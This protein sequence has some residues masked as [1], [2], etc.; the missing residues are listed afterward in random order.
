ML[1]LAFLMTTTVYAS[2]IEVSGTIS[3]DTTWAGVDTVKVVGDIYVNNGIT[4]TI[5]P[6]IYV[7]FQGHY[8]LEV[9][10]TLLAIGTTSTMITFTAANHS[11]GWNRIVLDNTPSSNDS[12]KI[13]YCKLE[14]GKANSGGTGNF[15]GAIY[16]YSYDKVLISHST[17]SNNDADWWGG[18]VYCDNSNIE[19]QYCTFQNNSAVCGGG[20][21]IDDCGPIL[22]NNLITNNSAAN[23]GGIFFVNSNTT[24]INN[25]IVNNS[26][27]G[28]WFQ[29]NSDPTF[30]NTIIY[31]STVNE[32]Y[33]ESNSD[34]PNFYY[35]DIEGGTSWFGGPGAGGNFTGDYENCID[36]NPQ[37][38]G[39]GDHPY[40]ISEDSPCINTGDPN[41]TTTDVG[42]YDL[43]AESRIQ[44][45]II[46]IGAYE[47]YKYPDGFPGNALEFDGS[48]DYVSIPSDPSFDN[49]Q[50]TVEFWVKTDNPGNWDG[51]IDKG[52]STNTDWYFLTGNPGQT[53]GVIFGIG[54]GTSRRELSYS[55]NDNS[56]HHVAG[57]FDGTTMKLIIDGEIKD[58]DS[59]SMSNTSNNICL[60]SRRDLGWNFAGILEEVVIWDVCRSL[61]EIRENKHLTL[62]GTEPGLVSYYQ[63]NESTGTYCIELISNNNGTL[64]NM[65]TDSCWVESTIPIGDGQSVTQIVNS[66]GMVYFNDAGLVMNVNQKTGTDTIVVTRI[67]RVPNIN[68]T[69]PEDVFDSQYWVINKFGNGTIN[70]NLGFTVQED[71]TSEDEQHPEQIELYTRSSNVDTDWLFL[72]SATIVVP[73]TD[74][75]GFFNITDFSQFIICRN[76]LPDIHIEVDTLNFGTVLI[77]YSETDTITIFN[78]GNDTLFVT[79]ISNNNLDFTV[80]TTSCTISPD[81]SLNIQVTYSPSYIGVITDTLTITSN[82]PDEPNVEVILIGEGVFE[83]D[84]FPGNALEFDGTDDYVRVAHNSGLPI[85]YYSSDHKFTIS[86]WVKGNGQDGKRVFSEGYDNYSNSL[87]TIGTTDEGK[88]KVFIQMQNGTVLLNQISSNIA[89]DNTWHHIVWVDINNDQRLYID[90]V[91]DPSD[92]HYSRAGIQLNRTSIGAILGS[93]PSDFFEGI[94]DEVQIW[95]DDLSATQ[96]RENMHLTLTGFETW[97]VSYLQFNEGSGE[98]TYDLISENNGT[99]ID[100]EPE[101][102]VNSTIPA[103]GGVSNTQTE[104]VGTVNFT[105]TGLSMYFNSQNGASITVTRIDMCPNINPVDA[106]TVFDSQYW[107]VNRFGSGSFNA[108]LTFTI[109]EDLTAADENNPSNIKLYTRPSNADTN[110]VY[111]VDAS[112]VNATT[113]EA[114]FDGITEFSQFIIGKYIIPDITVIPDSLFETLNTDGIATQH[115]FIGNVGNLNLDFTIIIS[116]STSRFFLKETNENEKTYNYRTEWLSL[117]TYSGTVYPDSTE[118]ITVYFDAAGLFE[119]EYTKYIIITSNDPDEPEVIVPVTLHVIEPNIYVEEDSLNFGIVLTDTSKVDT[120]TIFNIGTDT[121][122]VSDISNNNLDFIV[123]PAYCSISPDDSLDIQVTFSP[124]TIGVITDTLYITS[125]DPDEPTVTVILTGEG[126]EPPPDIVVTPA[127]FTESLNPGE[128]SFQE[129]FIE[130]TGN[131]NL[132]FTIIISDSTSRFFFKK[133]NENEK[134]YNYRT[135]WLSLE[136]YS[137]TVYPD[138]TEDITVYFDATELNGGDYSKYLIITSNDPDEPEIVVPVN[139]SVGFVPDIPQNVTISVW[140]DSI[141]IIWDPVTGADSYKVYSSDNAFTGFTEDMSGAFDGTSWSAPITEEKKFYYVTAS[142]ESGYTKTTDSPGI[143]I[144]KPEKPGN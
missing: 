119:G 124:S 29:D 76:L 9:D 98:I 102:W 117:E 19:I 4:L 13:V 133:T 101:D 118:D 86:M 144:S 68:P 132:D 45:G 115:L 113:D 5:A 18:G 131:G 49:P 127:F 82:D 138:S 1:G 24:L 139:L 93:D 6:G 50:F 126:A 85:Y 53:D 100:M 136:T 80:D 91:Q 121:L 70:A 73:S 87:F 79:D 137:G 3:S 25:T 75:A 59:Y 26:D 125:N 48:D 11:T 57:T 84:T 35:C 36:A 37:F 123:N 120:F 95:E 58:S 10:G 32:V 90:G 43:S 77:V 46:D 40:D 129:L 39:S 20:I 67:N 33:L 83:T 64:T 135:E 12:S 63:F 14:Y 69:E 28:I 142:G 78:Y 71:L 72:S 54:N 51:I 81:D 62:E 108:D 109:S 140:N 103:G 44:Q 130:N 116:D 114:T 122:F 56:W 55:W 97:L 89:F 66:A 88:V 104:A 134:T 7:E 107:V 42:E 23:A 110:W 52:R 74:E 111:L 30:R 15:G 8:R 31:G 105:D 41:T 112:S 34:D 61:S 143:H 2:N 60:G 47:T 99:L 27:M 128:T 22:V 21:K 38:V 141:H 106:D 96:I 17:F 65:D 92:F 94:I 16:V